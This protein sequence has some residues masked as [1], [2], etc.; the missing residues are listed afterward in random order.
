MSEPKIQAPPSE[1]SLAELMQRARQLERELRRVRQSIT[2]LA[3]KKVPNSRFFMGLAEAADIGPEDSRMATKSQAADS[4]AVKSQASLSDEPPC[5]PS[6]TLAAL[7][8]QDPLRAKWQLGMGLLHPHIQAPPPSSLPTLSEKSYVRFFGLL[9]SGE[10]W[11]CKIGL[12]DILKENEGLIIGRDPSMA[13]VTIPEEGVS[14]QHAK[15]ELAGKHLVVTD[16]GSTNGIYI[17]GRRLHPFE[18]Q[19]PLR[20]GMTLGLGENTLRVEINF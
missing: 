7:S 8:Y 14:R 9:P 4:R 10:P 12:K 13:H 11:Q 16:L 18:K 5:I 20:E 15:L 2:E 3:S 6:I 19:V 1:S 17:N